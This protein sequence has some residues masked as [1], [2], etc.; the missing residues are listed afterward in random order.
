[1]FRKQELDLLAVGVTDLKIKEAVP[2]GTSSL[3]RGGLER[4][5]FT[6]LW[7]CSE[8]GWS[9]PRMAHPGEAELDDH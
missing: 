6:L 7:R 5:D 2:S 1:M 8:T 3:E 4:S 9:C